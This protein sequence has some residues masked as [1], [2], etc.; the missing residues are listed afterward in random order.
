VYFKFTPIIYLES[1]DLVNWFVNTHCMLSRVICSSVG[2]LP[3]YFH[4]L[5]IPEPLESTYMRCV[6][7]SLTSVIRWYTWFF[8]MHHHIMAKYQ[9]C[10]RRHQTMLM[11]I[12]T[13]FPITNGYFGNIKEASSRYGWF[14]L[15]ENVPAAINWYLALSMILT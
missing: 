10:T 9:P 6:S 14:F 15:K 12:W 3:K 5:M 4:S 8:L 13:F 11:L 2:L 7:K 1:W